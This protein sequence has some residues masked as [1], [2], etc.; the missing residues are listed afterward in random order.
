VNFEIEKKDLSKI[1]LD[2]GLAMSTLHGHLETAI[3]LG[4]PV[5]Y[6]RLDVTLNDVNEVEKRIRRPPINSSMINN[7]VLSGK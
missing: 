4:L 5:N 2:R 3:L 6:E 1:C 7:I